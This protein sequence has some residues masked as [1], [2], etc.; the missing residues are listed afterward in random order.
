MLKGCTQGCLRAKLSGLRL[1]LEGRAFFAHRSLP[2]AQSSPFLQGMLFILYIITVKKQT[3]AAKIIN[4]IVLFRPLI[5]DFPECGGRTDSER[6]EIADLSWETKASDKARPNKIT[7]GR[8]WEFTPISAA[9][10]RS[11]IKTA[12]N[13]VRVVI[14]VALKVRHLPVVNRIFLTLCLSGENS[15]R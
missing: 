11:V 14:L 2:A 10:C 1:F 13:H 5:A 12:L 3:H 8:N 6:R 9:C 15:F 4:K 7:S